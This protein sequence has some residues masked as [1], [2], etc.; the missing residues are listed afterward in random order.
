MAPPRIRVTASPDWEVLAPAARMRLRAA[1]ES[2][3]FLERVLGDGRLALAGI[4][5]ARPRRGAPARPG[6]LDARVEAPASPGWVLVAR[7]PSGALTFHAASAIEGGSHRFEVRLA[8]PPF[9]RRG[10]AAVLRVFFLR[11]AGAVAGA[12]LPALARAWEK[13]RFAEAHVPLGLVR[14]SAE[15]EKL[16]ASRIGRPSFP[17]AKAKGL[18]FLHGTFS[19]ASAAFSDLA[20]DG[21]FEALSKLYE[22]RVFAFNHLTVGRS[23]QENATA[24]L[25]A[26]RGA[27]L[28]S[29]LDIVTHSRGGLVARLLA[30]SA[31]APRVNRVFLAA[32][33]NEGT[34]LASP[35]RWD[36]LAAWLANLGEMFPGGALAFGLDFAAEALVW[37]ASRAGGTL[38]GIAAMDPAGGLVEKLN[39]IAARPYEVAAA[40]ARYEPRGS[41]ARRLLD[42]A[43]GVFFE[44]P[45]DLVVPTEGGARLGAAPPVP[46]ED[47]IRFGPG[48]NAGAGAI[49][50]HLNLFAQRET[51]ERIKIFLE[52]K[53][54]DAAVGARVGARHRT[55]RLS[56][57]PGQPKSPS[58]HARSASSPRRFELVLIGGK[59][60]TPAHLLASFGGARVVEPFETKG[61]AAGERMR[62]IIAMHERVLAALDG[63]G[64]EPLPAAAELR[65]YGTVLFE[66]LFPGAVRRLWDE[67]RTAAKGALE[68][69]FT[70]GLDWIADKPWE[71][72]WDSSRRRFLADDAV[73][74]RGVFGAPPSTAPSPGRGPLHVLVAL[75]EPRDAA[76]VAARQEAA[77]IR[78]ALQPLVKAGLVR[79]E[80]LASTSPAGLH[81]RLS[82]GRADVLH[83][84]GHGAF[85]EKE[86]TG[87][88]FFVDARGRSLAVDT[89][90]VLR[91]LTGRALK[92]VVLNACETGRGGRTDFLRGVAPAL[93]VGGIPAVLANQYKVLD[94]SA[95]AFARHLY[96]ALAKGHSL[97]VAAREARVAVS[98]AKGA[99]PMDWAVPVLY[100]R[101]TSLVFSRPART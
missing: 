19:H 100:A 18:L 41:A 20:R 4:R 3:P 56:R 28:D 1:A 2:D 48:G 44:D 39:A 83:F 57:G 13:K 8:P 6:F 46:A 45:N 34:P 42:A 91:L 84:V 72:A 75:A 82:A 85:D 90:R 36:R 30:S 65:E 60:G 81:R 23:P 63:G 10:P 80:V 71:L 15:G 93:L 98:Y 94:A 74:V 22:G 33:P 79:L 96:W 5:S 38:P 54:D 17:R 87:S 88:L 29:S 16:V 92:L 86:K 78:A 11:V 95:T 14:L 99:E 49:V 27:S 43:A 77:A 76:P 35:A 97:G 59:G 12:L 26:V 64:S 52:G 58:K 66:T 73:L 62:V 61:G 69:V 53:E 37:M 89:D 67:A 40:V 25:E 31:G 32:S 68:V 51:K 47:V 101:D 24:L 70:P 55:N 21:G 50:H 9:G 7:H